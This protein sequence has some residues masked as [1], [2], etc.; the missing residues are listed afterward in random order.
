MTA[1]SL[2]FHAGCLL[3]FLRKARQLQERAD[4]LID[5]TMQVAN[6][7]KFLEGH[8]FIHRDLVCLTAGILRQDLLW[9]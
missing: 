7:M 1:F 9:N 4:I 2:Y 8:K 5:M 6:G 3:N